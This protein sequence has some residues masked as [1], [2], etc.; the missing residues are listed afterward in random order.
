[1]CVC[2]D[3][4]DETS[5]VVFVHQSRWQRT[6]MHRYGHP[7]CLIDATYNTTVYELPLFML[8]VLTNVGFVVVATF[9]LSDEQ[10]A[11]IQAALQVIRRW[12][13]EWKPEYFVSDFCEAQISAVESTLPGLLNC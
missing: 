4:S 13:P 7:V 12:C 2:S 8:C 6:M 9:M 1:M 5:S 10:A 11:S 3:N